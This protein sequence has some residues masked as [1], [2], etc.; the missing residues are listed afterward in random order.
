M[1]NFECAVCT[2]SQ[3]NHS[4]PSLYCKQVISMLR[5]PRFPRSFSFTHWQTNRETKLVTITQFIQAPD[6]IEMNEPDSAGVLEYYIS[7]C[8]GAILNNS[9]YTLI[10]HNLKSD[11]TEIC[12]TLA[13]DVTPTSSYELSVGMPFKNVIKRHNRNTR[14]SLPL[15][16]RRSFDIQYQANVMLCSKLA[17]SYLFIMMEVENG[18]DK[19]QLSHLSKLCLWRN[20]YSEALNGKLSYKC[21]NKGYLYE[22]CSN[23]LPVF[24]TIY[25]QLF[26]IWLFIATE[27]KNLML[28]IVGSLNCVDILDF[29]PTDRSSA[30]KYNALS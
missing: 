19:H 20:S 27:K 6:C 3:A 10:D 16:R 12:V 29:S 22:E 2:N 24:L 28:L 4:R 30:K 5:F 15:A 23:C 18:Q 26:Q 13:H 25:I 9:R 1:C 11:Y 8:F 7:L 17:S 21:I 14:A